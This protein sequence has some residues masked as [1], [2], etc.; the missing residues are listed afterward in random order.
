RSGVPSVQPSQT[1]TA[2]HRP[3]AVRRNCSTRRQ[4]AA[5]AG[6]GLNTGKTRL[7]S[8]VVAC[9]ASRSMATLLVLRH[10]SRTARA[11]ARHLPELSQPIKR[12]LR[13]RKSIH[14]FDDLPNRKIRPRVVRTN[15]FTSFGGNTWGRSPPRP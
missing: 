9:D 6:P 1:N 14:A 13:G 11:R 3:A 8:V 5:T 10:G 2:S 7:V 15:R 4:V 12:Y